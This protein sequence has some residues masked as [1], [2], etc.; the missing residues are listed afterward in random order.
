MQ[1]VLICN[2]MSLEGGHE[3]TEIKFEWNK[4]W[5]LESKVDKDL[6]ANAC[7]NKVHLSFQWL[8]HINSKVKRGLTKHAEMM[9]SDRRRCREIS[10][11]WIPNPKRR[12][13]HNIHK[14]T[15]HWNSTQTTFNLII[16]FNIYIY[17][18]SSKCIF[19]LFLEKI[20]YS[21]TKQKILV[22]P[23][24]YIYYYY[25]LKICG[26]LDT[27]YTYVTITY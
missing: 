5:E 13:L 11:I 21:Y 27:F 19:F 7:T 26:D 4:Y 18:G 25:S 15:I 20:K 9:L 17:I 6:K 22:C 3:W 16:K 12:A 1:T 10:K 24:F 8:N 2:T 23:T 14:I